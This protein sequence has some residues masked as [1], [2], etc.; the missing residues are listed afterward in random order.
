MF[1]FLHTSDHQF[2][3]KR[4]HSTLMPV[5]LLK[6]LLRY[7]NN[8]GSNMYVC[9]LDASKAFDRV[10]YFVLFRKLINRGIPGY[11]I[12]LLWNWYSCHQASVQRA[13]IL[14]N[15]FRIC[16]GVRQGEILS[17]FLFAVYI[18]DLSAQLQSVI[19]GCHFSNIIINHFLFAYDAVIFPHLPRARRS[20]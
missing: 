9:Y 16:N 11:I 14:T 17:P 3:F 13:D 7:Y 1:D 19:V 10:D 8:H 4:R 15:S 12:R 20:C 18:D 2:G 5:M 6:E